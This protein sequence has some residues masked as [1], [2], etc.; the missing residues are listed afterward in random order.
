MASAAHGSTRTVRWSCG[1]D[2][3]VVASAPLFAVN[4]NGDTDY[5]AVHAAALRLWKD[6]AGHASLVAAARAQ[7]SFWQGQM[8]S[9][10]WWYSVARMID[11]ALIAGQTGTRPA[12]A[13]DFATV[14]EI[15][16]NS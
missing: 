4:D 5:R 13:T 7:S 10:R 9:C 15:P 6:H 11:R 12:Y 3:A 16:V 1:A 2:H 8:T 14:T